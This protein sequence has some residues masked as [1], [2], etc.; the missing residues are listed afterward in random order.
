MDVDV[1]PHDGVV[2]SLVD[3]NGFHTQE[4]WLEERLRSTEAL[5]TDGDDL[6]IRQLVGL[7]NGRRCSSSVH[8][9]LKVKSDVAEFF[10]DVTD[11]FTLCGGGEG[12]ATLSHDLH[13]VGGQIATSQVQTEDGVGKGVTFVDGDGVGDT[14]SRVKQDTGGTTRGVEG[15]DSLDGNVHGRCSEG[16]KH[17]LSH[18]FT[19]SLGVEGSFS[20]EDWRFLRGHTE[21]VV[22]RVVPDLLHVIPVG[23]DTVLNGV[24]ESE[25]T[26][27]ALSLITDVGILLPHTDHDTLVTRAADDGGEHSSGG[28]VSGEPGLHHSGAIVADKSRGFVVTHVWLCLAVV[29]RP[30]N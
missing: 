26:S 20:Q 25:D 16:L 8:L 30:V 12:V 22:E 2:N 4:G 15:E 5:V 17:D 11:D 18:L 23:D 3:A 9:T 24:L 21:L 14:I 27:L 1:T 6:T 19:V 10:L 7:V 29:T 13:E 28:V